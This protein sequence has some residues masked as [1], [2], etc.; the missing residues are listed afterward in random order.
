VLASYGT[1]CA[2]CPG[3]GASTCVPYVGTGARARWET[4][5]IVVERTAADIL[6]DPACP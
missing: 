5:L 1:S 4:S 2:T 6:A 3:S